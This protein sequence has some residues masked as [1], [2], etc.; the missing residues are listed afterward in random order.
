[1][2]STKTIYRAAILLLWALALW[3]SWTARGI[4][5][6]GSKLLLDLVGQ[7]QLIAF[8]APR[9]Y[10]ESGGQALAYLGIKA[11]IT[12]LHRLAQLFSLML[13]AVPTAFYSLALWRARNEP[14]LL[15]GTLAIIAVVFMTTSFF[16]I[17]EYNTTFAITTA[18]A[19][20]LATTDRLRVGEGLALALIAIVFSR[21]Y[22]VTLYHGPL[23]ALMTLWRVKNVPERPRAATFLYLVAASFFLGGGVVALRSLIDPFNP[24]QVG[25]TWHEAPNFWQNPQFDVIFVAVL[26]V[27]VWALVK[28]ADLR[29]RKPYLWAC[30]PLAV[31]ALS[32]LM[33]LTDTTIARPLARSHYVTRTACGLVVVSIVLFMWLHVSH[34]HK[35]LQATAVLREPETARRFL[36]FAWLLLLATVPGDVFLT[37]TWINYLD[38]LR[39]TVT[40]HT[41]VLAFEDTPL[42]RYPA[43]LLVENWTL[44]AQSVL[45]HGKPGDAVIAPPRTFSGL[46]PFPPDKAPDLAPYFW[47]E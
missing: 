37:F 15:A 14:V 32:P 33:V 40:S 17:G 16:I 45:L 21:S 38:T 34:L 24:P 1:M 19:V 6:D 35:A 41:G 2:T 5:I 3:H 44:P 10:V 29:T 31:L 46:T 23:L 4:F 36:G 25:Q 9:F 11:G 20:W 47:R 26:V 8:R 27:V 42:A 39:A 22:E 28:P 7:K 12:D 43:D 18:S 13:F 30:L